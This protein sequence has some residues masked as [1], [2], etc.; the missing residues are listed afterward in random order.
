MSDVTPFSFEGNEVRT[1]NTKD[2]VRF[3]VNDVC[4]A[5]DI[6]NA[7]M[8]TERIT[9]GYVSQADVT[10]SLGRTRATNVVSE[11]GL[12][13]LIFRSD[14][15]EAARFRA[16]VFE[17]VLP[18]IRKDGGYISPDA[19]AEQLDRLIARSK[20]QVEM[21]TAAAGI[22]DAKW[23]ETKTR[24][25]IARGLG[26]EPEVPAADRPLT[27]GE[28][29]EEKGV[30]GAALRSTS[31][32]FGKAIKA[33]YRARHGRDPG[34]APRFVSGTTRDVAAYTEADR[35]LFDAVWARTRPV[36]QP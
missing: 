10:D 31:P 28:Y 3:V 18:A 7:R 30:T 4:S 6:S 8:A 33:E 20:A 15:P 27:T 12:Y 2:G 14:K 16:W 29:L 34:T 5:L 9:P 21:L 32:V 11:P 19:T 24:H 1:V 35:P 26:E 17:E 13:E 23:L 36:V 25:V 22:V